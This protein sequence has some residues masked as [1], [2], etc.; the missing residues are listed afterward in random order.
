MPLKSRQVRGPNPLGGEFSLI[1]KYFSPAAPEGFL[2]VGDDC[3][4]L[5]LRPGR[6]WVTS[7]DLLL[8]GRHFAADANPQHLGHKALAVNISD[9]AAMGARPEACLLGLALPKLDENWLQAFSK[10]FLQ[11]AAQTGCALVGGDTTRS[12]GGIQISV[13][14]LGTVPAGQALR[15]NAAQAGDD[16]WISGHLGGAHLA[17]Q[18]SEGAWPEWHARLPEVQAALEQPMPPWQLAQDL[19][20]WAHAG[21]DISDG[22]LQDLSHVLQAS[23]CGAQLQYAQLPKHPALAGLPA[24]IQY[25]CVLAGGEVYQLCFMAPRAHRDA[26][27][28]LGVQ[29]GVPLARVGEI[30]AQSSLLVL[31]GDGS[32]IRLPKGGYD[33]FSSE[34][35]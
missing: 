23:A 19:I 33:H 6:Q 27:A 13:T 1:A 32:P 18:L 17:W 29:Q 10:G 25:E 20:Q 12:N 30:T 2:G 15:R 34:T 31:D 35:P 4:M 14:V 22:L 26:I 9:L 16:I 8:Q 5:P 11:Y 3:A 24:G 7:T 28:A 21:L